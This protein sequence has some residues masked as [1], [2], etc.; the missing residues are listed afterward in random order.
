MQ[1]IETENRFTEEEK[2]RRAPGNALDSLT[3]RISMKTAA[4]T[5]LL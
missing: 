1:E 2:E 3:N 4:S 5:H